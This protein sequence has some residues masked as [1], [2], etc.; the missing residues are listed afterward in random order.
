MVDAFDVVTWRWV[1]VGVLLNLVS[2]L[3]RAALLAARRSTRRCRRRIRRFGQ[4]FS[5]FGVGLLGNAV[6]PGASR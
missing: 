4:V 2:A 6:L 1:I 3:A 5:A